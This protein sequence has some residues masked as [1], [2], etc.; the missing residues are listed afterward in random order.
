M[1]GCGVL[2]LDPALPGHELALDGA[3]E[4]IDQDG[5]EADDDH[6]QHGDVGLLELLG[7]PRE[8][9]DARQAVDG[10]G[11]DDR[12]EGEADRRDGDP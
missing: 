11:R 2:R 8:A 3:D 6:A 1:K 10:L 4:L 12:G 7:L 5:G 9:A